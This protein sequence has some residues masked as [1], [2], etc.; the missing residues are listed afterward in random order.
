MTK[1]RWIALNMSIMLAAAMV[2]GCSSS[3]KSNGSNGSG[4]SPAPSQ[5]ESGNAKT[6]GA[7]DNHKEVTI[8]T[9]DKPGPTSPQWQVELYNKLMDS[10]N[11]K[12]PWVKVDAKTLAPGTDY[13]QKYDQA[14]LAGDAPTVSGM[15]TDGNIKS[16]AKDGTLADIS[17]LVENW[18]LRKEGKVFT[19]MDDSL[20]IN[21]KWYGVPSFLDLNYVVY[22]KKLIKEAGLDP[23]NIPTTFEEFG[24]YVGKITDPSKNRFGF[25]LMGMEWL[26]WPYTNIVWNAGGEMVTANSDGTGKLTF[27]EDPG[28]DAVMFWHDM[29]WK[30]KATQKNVLESWQ[31]LMND[32][33]QG[34]T[35]MQWL[36][37][38]S[39]MNDYVNKYGGKLDDLDIL[40]TPHAKGKP[41]YNMGGGGVWGI[42]PKATKEQKEAAFLYI[43]HNSYDLDSLKLK[44]ETSAS[45]N[46]PDINPSQRLDFS[47]LDYAKGMPESWKS[48]LSDIAKS[49]K[50]VPSFLNWNDVKN[51]LVKP[52]QEII[53]K[54]D[55]T[56]EEAKAILQKCADELYKQYPNSFHR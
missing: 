27:A 35:A 37:L 36:N 25:G 24:E 18:D 48:K 21:G 47:P 19:G 29:V 4:S 39:F 22:N 8:V 41:S 33:T 51:A 26:A 11:K 32:F 54:K 28:V 34:R 53:L 10:F 45:N 17:E 1:K 14:L 52:L 6:G 50:V 42:N 40:T 12:Y 30:Y 49:A 13:L 31:D 2:A 5:K 43:V 3:G 56:R 55:I 16:R 38:S 15:F 44:A 20:K 23:N 7:T 9:W 46:A